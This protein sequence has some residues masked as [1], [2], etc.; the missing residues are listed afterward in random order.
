MLIWCGSAVF[1]CDII[2]GRRAHTFL[3]QHLQAANEFLISVNWI[4]IRRKMKDGGVGRACC[5]YKNSLNH[6]QSERAEEKCHFVSKSNSNCSENRS[7]DSTI[8]PYGER[9]TASNSTYNLSISLCHNAS[10]RIDSRS[11]LWPIA[12]HFRSHRNLSPN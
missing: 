12:I 7:R 6:T 1:R 10:A 5:V 9:R 11:I 4:C 2:I 3:D 8:R